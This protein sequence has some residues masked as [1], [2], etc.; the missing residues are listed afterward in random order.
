MQTY[1]IVLILANYF[2]TSMRANKKGSDLLRNLNQKLTNIPSKCITS[3]HMTV[4]VDF[5][6]DP[7]EEAESR[8]QLRVTYRFDNKKC[9][10]KKKK[11][12]KDRI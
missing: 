12:K 8:K 3:Y 2:K 6:I 10:R 9:R 11:K 7:S 5:K 4:Q 1:L